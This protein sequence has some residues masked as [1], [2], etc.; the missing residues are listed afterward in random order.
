MYGKT[1]ILDAFWVDDKFFP[2]ELSP[3]SKEGQVFHNLYSG[4]ADHLGWMDIVL[5]NEL[6]SKHNITHIILQNLGTLGK[7]AKSLGSAPVC[8]AYEHKRHFISHSFP[9]EKDSKLCKPIYTLAV[10]GGWDFSEDD[11]QI[12]KRALHYMKFLLK[13]TRVDSITCMNNKINVT[14]HFDSLGDIVVDIEQYL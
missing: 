10:C 1:L 14:V 9:K 12:H 8:V 7:I 2:T 6:I 11:S 3:T 5:L 4:E 13:H